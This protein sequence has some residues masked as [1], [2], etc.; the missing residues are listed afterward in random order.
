MTA[1]EQREMA[2]LLTEASAAHNEFEQREL[3]GVYDQEWPVWY[4]EYLVKH[5]IGERLGEAITAEKLARLLAQY[6][7]EYT[8]QKRQE[9]WPDYYAA[10]LL[11]R[12]KADGN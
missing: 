6:D 1:N 5:G 3:N 7:K 2:G 4:A 11:E 9:S 8:T 12:R 10:Q